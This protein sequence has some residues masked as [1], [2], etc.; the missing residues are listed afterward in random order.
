MT[1][2]TF[3]ELIKQYG[4]EEVENLIAKANEEIVQEEA[5]YTRLI[6]ESRYYDTQ[7]GKEIDFPDWVNDAFDKIVSETGIA[8]YH[9]GSGEKR[10]M[11]IT[12]VH[13]AKYIIYAAG[14]KGNTL[15]DVIE[16]LTAAPSWC[17]GYGLTTKRMELVFHLLILHKAD[18]EQV[19]QE[20]KVLLNKYDPLALKVFA[21]ADDAYRHTLNYEAKMIAF[22][23]KKICEVINA[24][25]RFAA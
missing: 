12:C 15:R 14:D 5:I 17:R 4:I 7:N 20:L 21:N 13:F 9:M 2:T 18:R 11:A 24:E 19:K 1:T 23:E 22:A 25:V 16:V 8:V 10:G 6:P 3:K